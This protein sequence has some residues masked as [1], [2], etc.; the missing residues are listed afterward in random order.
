M[1]MYAFNYAAYHVR[2]MA[3]F[4][5]LL[6]VIEHYIRRNEKSKLEATVLVQSL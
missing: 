6:S 1:G 3:D 4:G 2:P 5:G